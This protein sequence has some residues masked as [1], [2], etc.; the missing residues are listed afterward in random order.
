MSNTLEKIQLPIAQ[1][2]I[3]FEKKFRNSVKTDVWLLDNIMNY[4]IQGKGK[5][6][7]PMFVFLTA[8]ICKQITE[9]TY[10]GAAMIELLHTATLLHDDN[11]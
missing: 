2:M 9:A 4:I 7:R 6:M 11:T 1:E 10:R 5:Q 8:G 3:E